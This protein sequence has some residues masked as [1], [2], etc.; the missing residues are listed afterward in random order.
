MGFR[1]GSF[2]VQTLR[3]SAFGDVHKQGAPVSTPII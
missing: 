3:R 2:R 1:L